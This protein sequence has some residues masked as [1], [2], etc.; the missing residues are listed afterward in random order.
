MS[1][2]LASSFLGVHPT[3]IKALVC[4]EREMYGANCSIVCSGKEGNKVN[5]LGG[6]HLIH[7]GT[8]TAHWYTD[9]Q[10]GADANHRL[11]GAFH[12]ALLREAK[13]GV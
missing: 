5:D 2:G 9:K 10:N 8:I 3:E 11:E 13:W 6:G 1:F 12:E 7:D 4:R